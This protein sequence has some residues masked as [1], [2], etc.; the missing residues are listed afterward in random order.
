MRCASVL[1]N[2]GD[3]SVSSITSAIQWLPEEQH[4]IY[5]SKN[6]KSNKV[7]LKAK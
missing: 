2:T 4:G 5:R 7:I 3:S 6:S 1:E